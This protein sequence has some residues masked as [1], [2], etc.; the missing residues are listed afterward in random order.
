MNF[1][2]LRLF[3]SKQFLL[4]IMVSMSVFFFGV[5]VASAALTTIN[6]NNSSNSEWSSV[7]VFLVD[8]TG[9]LNPEANANCND[10]NNTVDIINT[11]VASGPAG[12]TPLSLYFM[13][14]MAGSNALSG[15][16]HAISAYIDCNGAFDHT[17]PTNSNAIYIPNSS[18][19]E[20]VISGDGEWQNPN[21]WAFVGAN[22]GERPANAL[23]NVEWQI[24]LDTIAQNPSGYNCNANSV[25]RIAFTVAKLDSSFAYVCT[26]DVTPDA[27]Y[28]VPTLLEMRSLQARNRSEKLVLTVV[29]L[30][31][32]V[33][34]ISFGSISYLTY[35]KQKQSSK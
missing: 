13:A 24:D 18:N 20:I 35:R 4:T 3:I 16:N 19:G 29:G 31:S 32:V 34:A 23:M 5:S 30:V 28:N 8:A 27:A 1:R 2:I 6:T 21:N 26:Y 10:G 7:P 33:A 25:A 12:G 15:S 14:Q 17:D 11:Y 9:D 22:L